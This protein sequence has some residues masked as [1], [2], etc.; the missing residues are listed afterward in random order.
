MEA[1]ITLAIGVCV[2][3]TDSFIFVVTL[4]KV[5]DTWKL[6]RELGV[7]RNND[8]V[9]MLL[10]QS[11]SLNFSEKAVIRIVVLLSND[12]ILVSSHDIFGEAHLH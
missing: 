9:S 3:F 12:Q 2:I 1:T 11:E 5:W 7:Q 10:K 8:L 6:K 4:R